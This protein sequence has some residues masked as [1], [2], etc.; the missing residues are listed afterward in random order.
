[1]FD[2]L[3]SLPQIRRAVDSA[4]ALVC[5]IPAA[6]R[7]ERIGSAQTVITQAT[8]FR[9]LDNGVA[10]TFNNSEDVA[11]LL[12]DLVLAETKCCAQFNY[13]IVFGSPHQTIE[14]RVEAH[15]RLA[16]RLKYL[17][18]GLKRETGIDV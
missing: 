11:R 7:A 15:P 1:V 10:F 9:E 13:S 8:S 2:Q 18:L 14:L 3:R 6:D 4:M 16:R 17:F 5:T 12:L